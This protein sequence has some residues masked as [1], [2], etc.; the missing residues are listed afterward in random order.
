MSQLNFY[1]NNENILPPK[2]WKQ[3]EIELAYVSESSQD[4]PSATL[5]ENT[6]E[7]VQ[8]NLDKIKAWIEGGQNGSA[9]GIWEGMPLAISLECPE[10]GE[11]PLFNGYLDLSSSTAEYDCDS[12]RIPFVESHSLEWLRQTADSFSFAYL[13]S[14]GVI[15]KQD[16]VKTYYVIN[17]VPDLEQAGLVSIALFIIAKEVVQAVKDLSSA[18]KDFIGV[19]DAPGSA[20]RGAL[21]III[22]LIYFAA[23]MIAIIT[24]LKQLVEAL[25]PIP[26]Y[27][28][29]MRI[30]TLFERGCE[31]LGLTFQS[32]LFEGEYKDLVWLPA[33]FEAGK[34]VVNASD[35]KGFPEKS[36][37]QFID[38]MALLFN[39]KIKI[40][41]SRLI[42]ER[43]DYFRQN[44]GFTLKSITQ[45]PKKTNA[46]EVASNYLLK[47]LSDSEDPNTLARRGAI[48]Q[49]TIA[50][51]TVGF[52]GNL[53]LKGLD[54][55]TFPFAY[56]VR[57]TSQSRIERL[58][59]GVFDALNKL[60][61]LIRGRGNVPRIGNRLDFM[62]LNADFFSVDKL[63]IISNREG[64][65]SNK[66]EQLL[67]AKT[68]WSEFHFIDSPVPSD[69]HAGNQW[70]IYEGVEVPMCCED[71]LKVKNNNVI[72]IEEEGAEAVVMHCSYNVHTKIASIS[73]KIQRPY[74]RNI[75]E[76]IS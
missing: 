27:Y 70:E 40:I 68:L 61:G 66:N 73:Y 72:Y 75:R 11:V 52:K 51:I 9:P 56:A 5:S 17:R 57:K 30:K 21:A 22:N 65:L 63:L 19:F 64:L 49:V 53:T 71:L 44:S 8:A 23:I 16:F 74:S 10:E 1:L 54:E 43:K 31:Y 7:F 58:F 69:K 18:I 47:F 14:I 60:V 33:K 4:S 41:N 32:T 67:S 76:V 48:H 26:K 34:N 25:F 46:S 38:D 35:D 15:T 2:N 37:G 20:L 6:F 3:T 59:A 28:H 12:Y 42:F 62:M 55:R 24:L 45:T 50:P 39:A 13:Q 29:G 36:F